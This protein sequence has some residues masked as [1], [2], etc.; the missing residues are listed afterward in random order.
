MSIDT[1]KYNNIACLLTEMA[2][3]YPTREALVES[4]SVGSAFD[5][6]YKS[7]TF[8]ELENLSNAYARLFAENGV[9]KGCRTLMMMR[10][11]LEFTAAVFAAFKAGAVP[12]LIDPGM[13]RSNFLECVRSTAP[14]ALVAISAVHWLK[15]IFKSNFKSVKHSFSFGA[16]PPPWGLMRLEKA[17]T[18]DSIKQ[19]GAALFETADT[20][21]ENEAAIL[22]TTGST[23]PPKGVVYTHQ[24]FLAQVA[25]ISKVYGVTPQ[26]VDMS[27]FPLFA[28]FAVAMGMKSVIPKMDFTRPAKVTPQVIINTVRDHNVSFSFGSPALWLTM[29][30]YCRH[31][32]I[33]MPTLKKVLMAGAPVNAALHKAVKAIIAPDAET[34][35][36]Y[37]A[38]EALP[39][40]NFNGTEMLN[41][42]AKKS[43]SGEGYCVGYVNEGL[44]IKIIKSIDEIIQEWDESLVL[45]VGE[46]GEI[47]VKGKVVTRE[48]YGKPEATAMAKI[49]DADGQ[50]WHRMGDV[51]Y[52]DS[53]NRLWFCG[54]K[55]HRV[56]CGNR[57]LYSV[58]VESIFN[59]HPQVFRSALVGVRHKDEVIPVLMV[60]P[61]PEHFPKNRYERS[62]FKRELLKTAEHFEFCAGIDTFI[63]MKDFPVDIR[64][65]AKIFR[66]KLAVKATE[67]LSRYL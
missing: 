2:Q 33:K 12:I 4:V 9:G 38:T 19:T 26:L 61:L 10:P 15:Y 24:T 43:T 65:N 35:V 31:N 44:E 56:I 32:K 28:L 39:I 60:Q 59:N 3:T 57:I 21:P 58:C 1:S 7:L 51:G 27:G 6:K 29:A 62:N 8:A 67:T 11:G 42:T 53:R 46:R 52:F 40:S 37:G 17:A 34:M 41:E 25:I 30:N 48:Y 47:V 50:V 13:G 22:F 64:H 23:G 49:Y 20:T 36:P 16:C 5:V 66:E 54:R 45:P 55:A 18:A 14:E 63:F